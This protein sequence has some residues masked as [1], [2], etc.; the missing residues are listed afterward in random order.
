MRAQWSKEEANAWYQR[1]GWL[2]GF[3]YLPRTAVNWNELWQAETFDI[4]TIDEELGWAENVGYNTLRVNLP[5]IVWLHDR[6]GLF[7]R[8]DAF[9]SVAQKHGMQVM[10][11]LMDDCGFSGDEP[12]LGVQE[13]P[14]PGVHNSRA[15]AS[16]G[17]DTVCNLSA[18][19]SIERY[20]HDV[21][22]TF[23]A[24]GRILL[25]DLYNEP[26]N[27]GIFIS[28]ADEALY[29]EKLEVFALDL[30]RQAFQCAREANPIQPLT[31]GAWHIPEPSSHFANAY[32]HPI[33]QEALAQ[34][35]VISFHA[36]VGTPDM[37]GLINQ[38][39]SFGRPLF[40]TE[41]LARHVG[42]TFE[43]QLPLMRT[44]NI[45][46]YHWGLVAGKTQTTL[47][48]PSIVKRRKDYAHLWFH[49]VFDV[50]GIPFRQSE[51]AL[52]SRFMH[53]NEM[54]VL[55]TDMRKND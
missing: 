42:S 33:D 53:G 14:I 25:W 13:A 54:R 10:L 47:P 19:S 41:W 3:N 26:G 29:A 9:L 48:W 16:P 11:T 30:L 4:A 2:C 32:Q 17:R 1:Q 44:H 45:A 51:M 18:R 6:E 27:R 40:C 31:A 52:V 38:L 28:G 24:D 5:F 20:I 43:K 50:H 37:V 22:T 7:A 15:V 35:D 39:N 46:C 8:I 55:E 23:R 34:S 12:H 21:I 49:D 36:Y